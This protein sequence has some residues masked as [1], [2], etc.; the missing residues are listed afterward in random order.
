MSHNKMMYLNAI[1][2][3]DHKFKDLF[4]FDRISYKI[5]TVDMRKECLITVHI[6]VLNNAS[7][8]QLKIYF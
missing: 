8:A 3:F 2:D 4:N 1:C 7:Q 6:D 5:S